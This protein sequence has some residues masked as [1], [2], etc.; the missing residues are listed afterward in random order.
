MNLRECAWCRGPIPA[1]L[2]RDAVCCSVRCRQARHRFTTGA[3]VAQDLHDASLLQ[4]PTYIAMREAIAA[5]RRVLKERDEKAERVADEAE[6]I[7]AASRAAERDERIRTIDASM[8]ASRARHERWVEAQALRRQQAAA[9]A[10]TRQPQ[11]PGGG[12]ETLGFPARNGSFP[13]VYTLQDLAGWEATYQL[14]APGMGR[15]GESS[16]ITSACSPTGSD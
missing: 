13:V 2:R 5:A 16:S 4:P 3:G 10:A 8:A 6:R 9:E 14:E 1:T 12:D 15:G 7:A 11:N